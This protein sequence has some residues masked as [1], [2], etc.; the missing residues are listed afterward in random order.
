MM[1]VLFGVIKMIEYIKEY[2]VT[3]LDFEYIS[4]NV[5]PEIIELIALSEVTVRENLAYYNSIGIASD[6]AKI[7]VARP[8]LILND[9]ETIIKTI[10]KID[11][12]LFRN[13]VNKS[14][15]DLI[16]LGV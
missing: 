13:V 4:H 6:I 14:I 10:S 2:G 1:I 5:K 12:N 3:N 16:I 9:K 15:E 7:I 8:D 11:M